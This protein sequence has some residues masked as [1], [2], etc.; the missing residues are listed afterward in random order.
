VKYSI[1]NEKGELVKTVAIDIPTPVMMHDFCITSEHENSVSV[2]LDLP[3]E[4]SPKNMIKDYAYRFNRDRPSRIG[5]LPRYGN[6]SDVQWFDFLP[7]YIFHTINAFHVVINGKKELFV[8]G[9][10]S[11]D[12]DLKEVSIGK[13]GTV[14]KPSLPVPYCYRINPETKEKSEYP[15]SDVE[16]EFP[17][18]HPSVLGKPFRYL[19]AATFAS[20]FHKGPMFNGVVK[21][22]A[23]NFLESGSFKQ[24][25]RIEFG[26]NRYGGECVFVPRKNGIQEDDGYLLTFVFDEHSQKSEFVVYDSKTMNPKPLLQVRLPQR[27]PYGFHGIWVDENQIQKQKELLSVSL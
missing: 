9:C 22:D 26:T 11:N 18:I 13:D 6:S 2:F 8:M 27:V 20:E 24:I 23:S 19:Y 4:F 7:G 16:C 17:S 5:V 3:L 10:R 1:V 15:L 25:G 12:M 21:F 14:A